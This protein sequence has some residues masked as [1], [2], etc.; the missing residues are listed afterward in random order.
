MIAGNHKGHSN[1]VTV[2]NW[3][4]RHP[5]LR[6]G[7]DCHGLPVEH[8]I[9]RRLS[10]TILLSNFEAVKTTS[11]DAGAF[12][13]W[14]TTPWSLRSNLALG[15]NSS[16]V[17]SKGAAQVMKHLTEECSSPFLP[18]YLPFLLQKIKHIVLPDPM[19]LLARSNG[20][21]K[22]C[23][24]QAVVNSH[25][26]RKSLGFFLCPKSD[27]VVTPPAELVDDCSPR[28]YPDF[29]WLMLLEFTQKHY[30]ADMST[31][32]VFSN[33]VQQKYSQAI[34]V[35]F[36]SSVPSIFM[37]SNMSYD[38]VQN[39]EMMHGHRGWIEV[40]I[41]GDSKEV[42]WH[43]R[44]IDSVSNA[45][46][47]L[48]FATNYDGNQEQFALTNFWVHGWCCDYK[49]Q[50]TY[51]WT[52]KWNYVRLSLTSNYLR[53]AYNLSRDHK[54]DLE[55]EKER[56]LKAGGFIHTGHVSGSLNARDSRCVISGKRQLFVDGLT[57]SLDHGILLSFNL[58]QGQS[59]P[60][61]LH[62]SELKLICLR[63]RFFINMMHS[64]NIYQAKQK[65]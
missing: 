63:R 26:P 48:M 12:V 56:I 17:Y 64:S 65:L 6:L 51:C 46:Q 11:L 20:R 5:P 37:S 36:T 44:R 40:A 31:L 23:L 19:R 49:K 60:S 35:S 18:W 9:D 1:T 2:H 59:S 47:I 43:D 16:F 24:H 7:L 53:M 62:L 3:P 29:T 38:L 28:I 54:P 57:I 22:S 41:F 45:E 13:A 52:L 55:T 8:E 15:V 61:L 25:T 21:C 33:W 34:E 10:F 14:S 42:Y 32:E 27:K 50:P 39:D 30:R 58:G 4:P